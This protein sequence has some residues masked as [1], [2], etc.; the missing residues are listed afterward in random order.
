[1][2]RMA[3]LPVG[4]VV[5]VVARGR[6]GPR[7]VCGH[8]R[9][10]LFLPPCFILAKHGEGVGDQPIEQ[11]WL[12]QKRGVCNASSCSPLPTN[13]ED[14]Q[15]DISLDIPTKGCPGFGAGTHPRPPV[16]PRH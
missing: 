2:A 16:C 15:G 9:Y 11:R 4:S 8:L 12:H 3:L 10:L 6:L 1:M 5:P 14:L 13:I 7:E